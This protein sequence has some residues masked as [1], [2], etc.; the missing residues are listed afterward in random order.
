MGHVGRFTKGRAFVDTTSRNHGSH[1][2]SR[3]R[4]PSPYKWSAVFSDSDM[5]D[6]R[7]AGGVKEKDASDEY[8][9]L[10]QFDQVDSWL[11]KELF[12]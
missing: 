6:S 2:V 11:R 3:R 4:R 7:K 5:D 10:W 9:G 8:P 1:G 12:E